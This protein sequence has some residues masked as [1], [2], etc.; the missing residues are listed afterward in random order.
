MPGPA[1]TAISRHEGSEPQRITTQE[2]NAAIVRRGYH[3]FN[4]GDMKLLAE[5]FD[6]NASWHTPGRTSIAGV[7]KGR[8]AILAHLGRYGAET[9]GNFRAEL[10]TV[11]A[12]GDGRVVGVHRN[13]GQRNGRHLDVLCCIVF[14][15]ENGRVTSGR[16]H[17]FDLYAWDAFWS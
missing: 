15:V 11:L 14:K 1:T 16:E 17:F 5:L 7:R 4:T 9:A 3:A 10:Q 12:D 6:E 13:V 2:E 8:D